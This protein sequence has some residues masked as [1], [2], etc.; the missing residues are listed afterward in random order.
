[1]GLAQ[2]LHVHEE[3]GRPAGGARDRHRPRR[4]CGPPSSRARSRTRSAGWNEGFTTSAPLV[5]LALKGQNVLPVAHKLIL[6]VVPVDHVA[7]GDADGGGAGDASSSRSWCTSCRSGDLNPLH[8]DRV[9][10]LTGLYKRKRFQRQGDRQQVPQRAGGAHGVPP[11]HP[12]RV[13]PRTRSRMIQSVARKASRDAGPHPAA[14]G[15]GPL[16]GGDRPRSRRASTRSSASPAR[17]ARTSSCSARSSSRTA[18]SSAPTT[19]APCATACR[20]DDQ[21]RLRLGPGGPRLLRL[22]DEHPLP[23]A[24]SAGCCPSWTRPTRREP[25]QVY[26]YHDLLELFDTTTKLHATRPALRIERGGR[27][28]TY[29]YADLQELATRVGVFL[30][31]RRRRRERARDAVRQE[32]A[33]VGDG[34]LRHR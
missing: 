10:T 20:A 34:L 8:M 17:R 32:R 2:H 9:V 21:A 15:R 12:G 3:H 30:V 29:S 28:E 1:M 16:H 18:T 25:K 7:S 6:D 31:E 11:G 4:S 33:R 26:S 22:L 13:R 27:E 5:Y 24:A 19:S 14:L 23:G